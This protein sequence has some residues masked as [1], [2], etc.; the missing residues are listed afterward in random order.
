M[1]N[2]TLFMLAMLASTAFMSPADARITRL[3]INTVEPAFGGQAFGTTGAYERLLG[4]AYGEVDPNNIKNTI[5]QDIALAPRNARGMVEYTTDVEILRPADRQKGNGILFFNVVNRGNKHGI[6]SFNADVPQRPADLADNNALKNAGDGWMMRQGYTMVWFGWQPDVLPGASRVTMKVPAARNADGSA[7]T[8]VVRAEL[9]LGAAA[10]APAKTLNLSS[11]WFT[12]MTHASYPTAS[13]DNRKAF[14]DGFLPTLTVR[15]KENQPRTPI[16]NTE[17]SFGACTDGG[18]TPNETQICYPAGFQLGRLY[19]LIY[20]AK[21]PLVLGL[22]YAAARDIG[23]FLKNRE[24]D[25]SGAAN[26]VYRAGN[27]AILMGTSQSG[28]YI[29]SFLQLGFNQDEDSRQAF[30]GAYPHIGG[31]LMPL[32]VRF[33][34]PGRA[35]GDQ[36]D[37][38][39]PSYDFPFTYARQRDPLTGREQGVLDRCQASGTCPLIFHV[40]TALEM[41]E[42]RQS[43][44]LTDPLGQTD[45]ADPPNVRTFIQASTQHAAAQLPLPNAQPFGVCQQQSNPNPHTWTMRALL[46][47]LTDWVKDGKEPPASVVPRIADGTLVAADR[48]RFPSIPATTYSEVARPAVRFLGVHNPLHV[49]DH[50]PLYRAA[51]TS[52][53]ITI[54]PPRV[55]TGAYGVLVPQVDED[56][57]DVGGVRSIYVRAPLGTYTGWNLGRKD[58]FEDGFCSLQGSFVPF[59]ATKQERLETKDSRLSIEERYPSKEAYVAKIKQEAAELVSQRLL[60]PADATR[61]IGEAEQGG[62]RRGP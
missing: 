9:V 1:L 29:R 26:P 8:G 57:N 51:E 21:D 41:W 59:A 2:R 7:V 5:I 24:A 39:Y 12:A 10:T 23:S 53:V 22:G 30:E 34:Q 47:A 45:V 11:G 55:S 46:T 27:K 49:L 25:D 50:G 54:E 58:R 61:L 48:V 38:L 16:P 43:L 62:I 40:A 15:A 4:R 13:T 37:H 33:G 18:V 6:V 31:G 19:E 3:E 20:R 52:G 56:G 42:G 28:R 36:I 17:W 35:W 44:G 32:N 60:L 14:E